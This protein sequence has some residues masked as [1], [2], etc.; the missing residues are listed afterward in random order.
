[1][2]ALQ[3]WWLPILHRRSR[4]VQHAACVVVQRLLQTP[5]LPYGQQQTKTASTGSDAPSGQFIWTNEHS[6]EKGT[7]SN[8]FHCRAQEVTS[9]R[10]RE[11]CSILLNK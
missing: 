2:A 8:E 3:E 10:I 5:N 11:E 1:M 6:V 4:R 7:S 9:R